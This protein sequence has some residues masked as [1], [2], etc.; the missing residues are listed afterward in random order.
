MAPAMS[1]ASDLSAV[2]VD[3]ARL[4]AHGLAR[5]VR[6]R[7]IAAAISPDPDSRCYAL[8]SLAAALRKEGESE[9]ALTVLDAILALQPPPDVERA[10]YTVAIAVHTDRGDLDTARK[11]AEQTRREGVDPHLLSA[12]ARLYWELYDDTK[13]EEFRNE[14]RHAAEALENI[15]G[16]ITEAPPA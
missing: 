10:V 15:A 4:A 2:L 7:A 9:T 13:L 3:R 1:A 12:L 6:G 5:D 16:G 11:L 8:L 14:W